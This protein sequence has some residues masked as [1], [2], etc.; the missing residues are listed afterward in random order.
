MS[1]PR[2]LPNVGNTC[3]LNAAL[4]VFACMF[5][6]SSVH[7]DGEMERWVRW[8][9]DRAG[10]A[11]TRGR[12]DDAQSVLAALFEA[13][14][15]SGSGDAYD[16][17][18]EYGQACEFQTARTYACAHGCAR[19]LNRATER[20]LVLALPNPPQMGSC[21]GSASC[22]WHL[23]D[24]VAGWLADCRQPVATTEACP[25]HGAPLKGGAQVLT[26][27]PPRF[28]VVHVQ[29]YAAAGNMHHKRQDRIVWPLEWQDRG[30]GG[31]PYTLCA[32]LVHHGGSMDSGHYTAV[33]RDRE[34][35]QWWWC[36]DAVVHRLTRE[37]ALEILGDAYVAV[38]R[39]F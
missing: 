11:Y 32:G 30:W 24:L 29:R 9:A 12:Q 13:R 39:R 37:T 33:V 10:P 6:P 4:Q 3:F 34:G 19:I 23:A 17:R 22:T 2:G 27:P 21:S 20:F 8:W 5:G 1:G 14:S 28:W 18:I 36:N 16:D 38:Y 35:D 31:Q 7:V 15:G 26:L 25:D